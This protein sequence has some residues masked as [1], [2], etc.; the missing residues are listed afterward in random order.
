MKRLASENGISITELMIALVVTTLVTAAV[1]TWTGAVL[2]SDRQN[3]QALETIDELRYAKS[4]L[5]SE[6]RFATAIIPPASGNDKISFKQNT[7][8]ITYEILPSGVL[9]R[10]T[11]K[12]GD[13]AIEVAHGLVP[14]LSAL[15]VSGTTV[16]ITLAVDFDT[17]DS[18]D[19][20]TIHTTVKARNV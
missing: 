16:D 8:T 11:D 19:A 20:R 18:I 1:V 5:V 15:V 3:Q 12:P 14:S 10:T 4:R 2:R 17:T 13:A 9:R 6:L 7:T